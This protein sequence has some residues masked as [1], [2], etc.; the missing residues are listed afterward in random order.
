MNSEHDDLYNEI[1][2]CSTVV[3]VDS[4]YSDEFGI[5]GLHHYEVICSDHIVD[6]DFIDRYV[7]S[8]HEWYGVLFELMVDENSELFWEEV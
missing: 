4:S 7:G 1:V 8:Y 6:W 2:E 3:K 5:V